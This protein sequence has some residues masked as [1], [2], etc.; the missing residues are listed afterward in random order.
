M[1]TSKHMFLLPN[2]HPLT[3]LVMDE[4][5]FQELCS[6]L[7]GIFSIYVTSDDE[8]EE[9]EVMKRAKFIPTIKMDPR[10]QKLF[11]DLGVRTNYL[12]AI[13]RGQGE[14]LIDRVFG[15]DLPTG[16]DDDDEE[17]E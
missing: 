13:V 1:T 10:T 4:P 7:E 6:N 16:D 15:G 11:N 2:G 17:K 3:I 12:S 5:E 8:K 14:E 9:F